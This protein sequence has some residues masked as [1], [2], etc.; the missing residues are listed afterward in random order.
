MTFF[1]NNI[2]FILPKVIFLTVFQQLTEN[3]LESLK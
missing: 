1:Q 3:D 2:F